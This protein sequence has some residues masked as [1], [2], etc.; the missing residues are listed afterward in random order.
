MRYNA[1]RARPCGRGAAQGS[2][3][4]APWAHRTPTS[5]SWG[6]APP[7]SSAR[8]RCVERGFAG[9][10]VMLDKGL[11]VEDRTCPKQAG[12]P[13]LGCEPCR[14]T[15]GFSGAGAFS[16][17][18]LSLSSR[19]GRRFARP[20]RPRGRAGGHRGGG[21][22]VPGV[23]RRR[24]R[25]GRRSPPGG[26]RHT[27]ARHQGGPQARGLPAAPPG[28]GAGARAVRAHWSA[29]WSTRAWTCA[30][31]PP[32][33][34]CSSDGDA[35]TGVAAGG[36]RGRLRAAR[37]SHGGGH[38]PARGRLA[39]AHVPRASDSARPRSR[40]HRRARGGAQRGHGAR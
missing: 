2:E 31:A 15:T 38:R 26:G 22:R 5:S 13:C 7:A 27:P 25:G 14:I 10:I 39:G 3:G 19:G 16:D 40:G 9:R 4:G 8:S 11:A 6:P 24:P 35:C 33:L 1:G 28:H 32:A 21:R 30:S 36:P 37:P 18:K 29:T 20:H 17:G 34:R 23:R 12:G